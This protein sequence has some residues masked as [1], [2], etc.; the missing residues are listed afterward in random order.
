MRG[1]VCLLFVL[2]L[3]SVVYTAGFEGVWQLEYPTVETTSYVYFCE[4]DTR[5]TGLFNE[6]TIFVG[7][8]QD[9]TIF[10]NFYEGYSDNG[11]TSGTFQFSLD[12]GGISFSGS[13]YCDEGNSIDWSASIV[14]SV[15]PSVIECANVAEFNTFTIGGS[16]IGASTGSSNIDFCIYDDNVAEG[17]GTDGTYY[18]GYDAEGGVIAA[19]I[20]LSPNGEGVL[21]GSSLSYVDVNGD[22]HTIW[23]AGVGAD[24][25]RDPIYLGNPKVHRYD[26]YSYIH[27]SNNQNCNANNEAVLEDF[28][29]YFDPVYFQNYYV[30]S[31]SSYLAVPLLLIL[32]IGL[33]F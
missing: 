8:I 12:L 22:L 19:G 10:G 6:Q 25:S 5:V 13:I 14:S 2:A 29:Y 15:R 4:D 18:Y 32:S 21:P 23:W 1:F 27:G 3:S 16:W 24:Y 28:N 20:A 33:I 26:S 30:V 31:A 7:I 11:C 17:S 9:D